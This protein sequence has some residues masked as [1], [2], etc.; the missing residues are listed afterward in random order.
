[1]NTSNRS[2]RLIVRSIWS[3][4]LL[5]CLFGL[6]APIVSLAAQN[7]ESKSPAASVARLLSVAVSDKSLGLWEGD[8]QVLVYN[9]GV[10]SK[11]GVPTARKRSTYIHPIYGLDGE[12]LTDDF[13]ADHVDHRGLYWAWPHIKL[14]DVEYDS[15]N[16]RPGLQTRFGK[17]T[18][19][20][21]HPDRA[22]LGVENGWFVGDKQVVREAV[23]LDIH[24]AASD[25][26]A[27]DVTLTWTALD[28]PVT[29]R[30]A[31][32]KGYVGLSVRFG[33]RMT[34]VINVPQVR[35]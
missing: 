33:P 35:A 18:A 30:G 16:V 9:H 26:R 32:G 5:G 29:L 17:W 34:T 10:M 11:P 21:T 3:P 14:G 20:E 24:P 4:L 7:S 27:I 23:R 25:A 28:D 15:W 13:P 12:V 31:E 22:V 19:K 2:A 6:V 8:R 1:M